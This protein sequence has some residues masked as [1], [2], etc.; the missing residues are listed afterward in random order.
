MS[1]APEHS[2]AEAAAPARTPR[3]PTLRRRLL[4]MLAGL[5]AGLTLAEF[6]LQVAGVEIRA[7]RLVR[8]PI[9]GWRN[10]P[11][12]PGPP[13]PIN[14]RGFIGPE[15][16]PKKAPGTI[17]IFCLGDSCTAGDLLPS[18]DDTYPSQLAREL[19]QRYPD[20]AF[21]VINAGVGGYSSFQSRTWLEREIIQYEPDLIVLYFGWND[22]WPARAGGPDKIVSG[23][24]G[25]RLRSWLGW[26]KVIQ[27]AIKGYRYAHGRRVVP[28]K[29][30]AP[31]AATDTTRVL[32]VSL[33]DYAA[34]LRAMVDLIRKQ[35]G[36]A[37]LI[38]APDYLELAS[39]QATPNLAACL[40]GDEEAVQAIVKLHA[41]YNDAVRNV[42][43]EKRVYLVD[44]ARRFWRASRSFGTLGGDG[45]CSVP[46][47]GYPARLFWQ[48]PGKPIDFIHL[49][50]E[51]YGRL[52][53]AIAA[54]AAVRKLVEEHPKP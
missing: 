48:P 43:R 19:R 30:H 47:P 2:P 46:R 3:R 12:W 27:L 18:L 17:R 50:P 34:N 37:V 42:A 39:K 6:A 26:S 9:L 51:G 38:T 28:A 15:L 36:D 11:G 44:A 52:A 40:G 35:G 24:A 25:E 1:P 20:R 22:H 23:S 31:E 4:L 29:A 10:R 32:R 53:R 45:I 33:D 49:S 7:G 41:A 5:A 21:E 16:D 54:S 14:S 13:F 8:D